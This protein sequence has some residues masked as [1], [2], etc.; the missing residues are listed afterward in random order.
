MEGSRHRS[1]T[2][3]CRVPWRGLCRVGQGGVGGKG[4]GEGLSM[5]DNSILH[6]SCLLAFYVV[7]FSLYD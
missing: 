6:E 7:L 5:G 3:T 1:H 2:H 4:G